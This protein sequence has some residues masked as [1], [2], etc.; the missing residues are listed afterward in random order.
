MN[1]TAITSFKDSLSV[2]LKRRVILVAFLGFS[3]GLPLALTASTLTV[4]LTDNG[5]DKSTI[6][7]LASVSAP[8]TVKFFWSQ[9]LDLLPVPLLT[10]KMGRRRSW[11]LITQICLVITICGLGHSNPNTNV[12][13]TALWAFTVAVFS[14]SQDI[15]LDAYRIELLE[16]KDQGAGASV[17]VFGYR[18][19]VLLAGGGGLFLVAY[20]QSKAMFTDLEAWQYTYTIMAMFMFVGI[21][22]TLMAPN[23]DLDAPKENENIAGSEGNGGLK[24]SNTESNLIYRLYNLGIFAVVLAAH[25]LLWHNKD[26]VYNF[27]TIKDISI[28]SWQ[29]DQ[30]QIGPLVYFTYYVVFSLILVGSFITSL[31]GKSLKHVVYDPF[32]D[33]MTRENWFIIILFVIMYKFGDALASQMTPVFVLD[34]GFSKVDYGAYVKILGTIATLLGAFIGGVVVKQKGIFV[35]LMIGGILQMISNLM[36]AV[37]F[38]FPLNKMMLGITITI[39]NLTSGIGTTAFVAYLS[40][41]CNKEFTATQYALLSSLSAFARSFLVS[42]VFFIDSSYVEGASLIDRIGWPSYFIFT[43]IAAIPGLLLLAW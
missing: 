8:Y 32:G 11:A 25:I 18:M 34:I 4:W 14:A 39:E 30:F 17:Y 9:I 16:E 21:A 1:N 33:F 27:L 29:T 38:Y 36:F 41:L 37:L 35:A 7:L 2:Y 22:A 42:G 24:E 26:S 10:S 28:L 19:A 31:T 5:I 15:A 3:S 43:T 23:T 40:V 20:L 12:Y 13:I 6:G